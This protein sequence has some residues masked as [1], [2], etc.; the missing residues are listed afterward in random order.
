MIGGQARSRRVLGGMLRFP[1][2]SA[3]RQLSVRD[4][5]A[6][7]AELAFRHQNFVE[8]EFDGDYCLLDEHHWLLP[9]S[10]YPH[11]RAHRPDCPGVGCC[12]YCL[13]PEGA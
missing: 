5:L 9:E 3:T 1:S 11:Q 7:R 10:D 4:A 6:T 8:P 13:L 12:S 2:L